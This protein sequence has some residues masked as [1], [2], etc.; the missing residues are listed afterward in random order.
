[1][2]LDGRKLPHE[3]L[4]T[5]RQMAVLRVWDGEQPSEV[6]RSYGMC[7]TTIYRWLRAAQTE[8]S[9]ALASR[10]S[11]GAP[12][13]LSPQQEVQ[14][15]AWIDGKDPRQHGYES[16]L[17]T[18]R[19]VADMI[20]TQFGVKVDITTVGRLLRRLRITPQ[21]PLH[22]AYE[23]DPVAIGRWE[24]D[25]YPA[26]QVRA[27]ACG[28]EI[29]FLDETGV[30]SDQSLGR[31]WGIRGQTPVVRTSGKRQWVNA[32]SAV[33]AQGAFWYCVFKGRLNK[34]TFVAF[35]KK[36][37]HGRRNPIFLVVDRHPAHRAAMVAVFVQSTK[38][39]LELHFLPGYAPELNPDEF[40]WHHLKETGI[41]KTPLRQGEVLEA[42][43]DSDLRTMQQRPRL[44]RSFFHRKRVA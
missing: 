32:I 17:W 18:R 41:S 36:F 10:R 35:L 22:R 25:E 33:N 4:E 7:R 2:K 38:G 30:R 44:L 34:I 43:V 27:A 26:L 20:Q 13:K 15:R 6:I 5:I 14:V 23:R 3:T 29:F 24:H 11:P 8:G 31:T 16:G 28:A 1:V 39:R 21:K 19:I 40:V 12:F 37:L 9:A 42:R